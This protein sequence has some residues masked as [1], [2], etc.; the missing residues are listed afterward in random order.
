VTG[1]PPAR[2]PD[3]PTQGE[4]DD[5]PSPLPAK[6][7]LDALEAP[8]AVLDAAGVI[9]AVNAA[10]WAAGDRGGAA[11]EAIGPGRSYLEVCDRATG[12]YS[13]SGTKV[14]DG[15]RSVLRGESERFAT[16]YPC[17][18]DT[19]ERWCTMRVTPLAGAGG[20]AVVSHLD[21]TGARVPGA[22]AGPVVHALG[23][24]QTPTGT[25][26]L[27]LDRSG[28]LLDRADATSGD[29]T[30][31]GS[32]LPLGTT[33][34]FGAVHPVDARR[35]HDALAE[36]VDGSGRARARLRL[37]SATTRWRT[38]DVELTNEL[39]D[40]G[41]PAVTT[42]WSDV[43]SERREALA[44]RFGA[45]L[46][47]RLPI[48]VA[49]LDDAGVVSLWN[50]RAAD[51]YG[52]SAEAVLGRELT[53][54]GFTPHDPVRE[55]AIYASLTA[56]RRWDGD[57]DVQRPD[58]TS[59]PAF[60][61]FIPVRLPGLD[62]N[63]AIVT[64]V[65]ITERR[66]LEQRLERLALHDPLTGLP[67]RV[68]FIDRLDSALVR[69]RR[70]SSKVAVLFIDLDGFKAVNDRLGHAAGDE[71]LCAVARLLEG[72]LRDGDT[73]ARIAGDEF[74]V[75]AELVDEPQ[76]AI[77]MAER[78]V[79]A[80]SASFGTSEEHVT[81]SASIGIA[82]ATPP[83]GADAALRDAD[84]AMYR[85]KRMG[86]GRVELFDEALRQQ[87]EERRDLE[88]AFEG[89]VRDDGL[90]LHFQPVVR[91]GSGRVAAV[92]AV[93]RWE[94]PEHGLVGPDQLLGLAD[95]AGLT[96]AVGA[97]AVEEACAAAA[98]WRASHP[99]TAV[100]VTVGISV[101]QLAE[102]SLVPRLR[103]ALDRHGLAGPSIMLA[104]AEEALTA[105]VEAAADL[106]RHLSALGVGV[107]VDRVGAGPTDARFLKRLPV[108]RLKMDGA[109]VRRLPDD[110][111]DR[112]L[113]TAI[114]Q[115][116]SARGLEVVAT[117][118]R[119]VEQ[120]R[121]ATDLGCL[122]AQGDL[123]APPVPEAQLVALLAE[124]PVPLP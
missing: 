117:D 98:R 78:M 123:L 74:V 32:P 66:A 54:A 84:T 11:P 61:S 86:K 62:F 42:T 6:A 44:T 35:A 107:A 25:G 43:T 53:D 89:A 37:G 114:I 95:R 58:G 67:N 124:G 103:D 109:L 47:E 39:D 12:P 87:V 119:T 34:L 112:I 115:M 94:H 96:R 45:A 52:A 1:R 69:A 16:E 99:G 48:G 77:D 15:I 56:G 9:R 75:C 8:V 21:I 20:G 46:L 18:D 31:G 120:L 4:P 27:R 108:D 92:E 29:G 24:A 116:A 97:R 105:D 38:L 79:A 111:Q 82:L 93:L 81:L 113:A 83:A 101:R 17:P 19:G 10:W 71:V 64:S 28:R 2:G 57:Y 104:V 23:A 36:A 90:V 80:I 5:E 59:V 33:T 102:R 91:V 60:V 122:L 51:I 121:V 50:G 70:A 63:G 65:D 68:L 49:V 106:L 41:R 73:V 55:A 40:P 3:E 110:A 72:V 88:Q 26:V 85:A 22:G 30:G 76:I 13:R 100:P 118:V 7:V 14:A